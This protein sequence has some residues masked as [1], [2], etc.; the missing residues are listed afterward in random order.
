M[1]KN[2]TTYKYYR[3]QYDEE[4]QA[5]VRSSFDH[6]E[7]PPL[8]QQLQINTEPKTPSP[9]TPAQQIEKTECIQT[10]WFAL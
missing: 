6:T 10:F 1:L 2:N 7:I 4:T 5:N 8:L 3:N 9:E